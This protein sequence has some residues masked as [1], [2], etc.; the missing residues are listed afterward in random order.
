MRLE[1]QNKEVGRSIPDPSDLHVHD[2]GVARAE[3]RERAGHLRLFELLQQV[4]DITL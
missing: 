4:H 2:D 3:G 1:L